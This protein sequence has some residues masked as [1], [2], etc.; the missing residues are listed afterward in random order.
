MRNS[1]CALGSWAMFLCDR[2]ER[3]TMKALS[4]FRTT[5]CVQLQ[6]ER[7]NL[8]MI[9][10]RLRTTVENSA[11]AGLGTKIG[12]WKGSARGLP[13]PVWFRTCFILTR[14]GINL[15]LNTRTRYRP[16]EYESASVPCFVGRGRPTHAGGA[17]FA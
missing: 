2:T 7:T 9:G 14:S 6:A 17:G 12:G 15:R 4:C 5:Q 10:P 8:P 13:P 1:N 3:D 16:P 11:W